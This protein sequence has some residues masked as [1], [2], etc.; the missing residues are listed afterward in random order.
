MKR[1]KIIS[2]TILFL[3]M[4]CGAG[5][6][7]DN[8]CYQGK[9]TSLNSGTGCYNILVIEKSVPNGLSINSTI[10]FD[11]NIFKGTIKIGDIVYF[12]IVKYEKWVGPATAQCL[13]P[14]YSGELEQYK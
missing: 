2:S 1:K 14:K 6:D 8:L 13:W 9:V 10:A 4:L 3:L 12:N 11:P 5:C 7:N